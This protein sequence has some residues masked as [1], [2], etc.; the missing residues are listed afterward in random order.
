MVDSDK[1]SLASKVEKGLQVSFTVKHFHFFLTM[2]L[3]QQG[4]DFDIQMIIKPS[5]FQAKWKN[6][7]TVLLHFMSFKDIY[8]PRH[9]ETEEQIN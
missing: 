2:I 9:K 5:E 1:L 6:Y 8:E 7:L 3:P 4:T